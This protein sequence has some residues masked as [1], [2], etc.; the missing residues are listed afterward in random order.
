LSYWGPVKNAVLIVAFS[1]LVAEVVA[2][3]PS[4]FI[5]DAK[6][7]VAVAHAILIP[8]YGAQTVQK[9]EPLV[10][11]RS[12]DIWTVTG[13]LACAPRCVGGTAKVTLSAKDGRIISVIH[14]K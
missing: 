7:A 1:A 9:E 13:T 2:A 8:I 4:S 14:A 6:T 11:V 5:P 3:P 10:A 12:G